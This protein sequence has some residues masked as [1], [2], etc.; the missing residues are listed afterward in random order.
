M[1]VSAPNKQDV[2]RIT[3]SLTC[4]SL[5]PGGAWECSGMV[6][7]PLKRWTIPGRPFGTKT[8]TCPMLFSWLLLSMCAGGWF[9]SAQE[10]TVEGTLTHTAFLPNGAQLSKFREAFRISV[11]G[12]KW[13]ITESGDVKG[14]RFRKETGFDGTNLFQL[15]RFPPPVPIAGQPGPITVHGSINAQDMPAPDLMFSTSPLWLAFAS[16]SYFVE[17]EPGSVRPV[18]VLSESH[19]WRTGFKVPSCWTLDPTAPHLPEAV[20][21]YEKGETPGGDAS[22]PFALFTNATYSAVFTNIGGLAVPSGFTLQRFYTA[23]PQQEDDQP[24]ALAAV[25]EAV[26]EAITPV[27]ESRSFRPALTGVVLVSDCRLDKPYPGYSATY[28]V[29]NGDWNVVSASQLAARHESATSPP[30]AGTTARTSAKRTA[31]LCIMVLATGAFLP[32]MLKATQNA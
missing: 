23:L 13:I 12:G 2:S 26:A 32:L 24:V 29:T 17:A 18:W 31:I 14:E 10:Y 9:A 7:P 1:T 16:G 15:I 27:C 19:L 22:K 25:D 5:A 20:A 21:F 28:I 8:A 4:P 11:E 3:S 6:I 30:K